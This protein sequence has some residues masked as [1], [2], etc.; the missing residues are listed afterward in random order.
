MHIGDKRIK[1]NLYNYP[2]VWG[3]VVVKHCAASRRVSGS[4]PSGV[5]GDVGTDGTMCPGLD[6]SSKNEY[7]DT[8]AG[9]HGRT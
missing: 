9:K 4:I 6:S 1:H 3:S 7:Q 2:G 5:T 8:P